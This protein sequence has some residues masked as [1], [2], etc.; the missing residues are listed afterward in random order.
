MN[1]PSEEGRK[2]Q[3]EERLPVGKLD[4]KYIRCDD[5]D[6]VEEVIYSRLLGANE[7]WTKRVKEDLK[8]TAGD[9]CDRQK[10]MLFCGDFMLDTG[11]SRKKCFSSYIV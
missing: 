5:K 10:Q 3:V 4:K 7:A 1:R 6:G 9:R 11:Y 2:Q 8:S